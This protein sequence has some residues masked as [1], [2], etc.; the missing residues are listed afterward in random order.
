MTAREVRHNVYLTPEGVQS[1]SEVSVFLKDKMYFN[2]RRIEI[3]GNYLEMWIP[4]PTH[5]DPSL[6]MDILVPHQHVRFILA[7]HDEKH[8]GFRAPGTK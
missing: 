5:S 1:V 3:T 6:D 2:C 8:L 7:V 4:D